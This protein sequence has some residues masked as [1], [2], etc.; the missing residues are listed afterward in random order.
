MKLQLSIKTLD[1]LF[2][3]EEQLIVIETIHKTGTVFIYHS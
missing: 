1:R 3:L 2:Y